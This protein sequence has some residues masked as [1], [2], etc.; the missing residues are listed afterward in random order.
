MV[1]SVKLGDSVC[2]A[3]FRV[4]GITSALRYFYEGRYLKFLPKHKEEP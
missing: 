3:A 2:G 4:G 1:T